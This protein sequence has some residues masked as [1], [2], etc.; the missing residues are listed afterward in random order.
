MRSWQQCSVHVSYD[1]EKY[2]KDWT[3]L[4]FTQKTKRHHVIDGRHDNGAG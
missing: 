4:A 3:N 1:E 2:R